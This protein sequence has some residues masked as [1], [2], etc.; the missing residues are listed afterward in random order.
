[1]SAGVAQ[2]FIVVSEHA[3][4]VQKYVE[5]AESCKQFAEGMP[6]RAWPTTLVFHRGLHVCVR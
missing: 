4:L 3:E 6:L 5:T 1:M 2:V